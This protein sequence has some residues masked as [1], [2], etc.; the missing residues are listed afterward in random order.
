MSGFRSSDGI[1]VIAA[2][3]RLEALDPALTRPGRF[4]RKIEVAL[5][6]RAQREQILRL[7]A[8]NKPLEDD[9][10][11]DVLAMDTAMFSG[12]ALEHLL[13]EAA[14][15]AAR[16]D[17]GKISKRDIDAAFLS[18]TVG[19]E[20]TQ[21]LS[22]REARQTAVHE[23]GHALLTHL[24]EPETRLRRLSILPT[25]GA[26]NAAGYSMSIPRERTLHTRT[27]LE[28]RISIMLAGRAAEELVFGQDEVTTGAANDIS[29]ATELAMQMTRELGMYEKP[30]NMSAL[31]V[32]VA[33]DATE[34]MSR[35]Y[36]AALEI[37]NAN[38]NLLAKLANALFEEEALDE[39]RLTELLECVSKIP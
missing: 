39:K 23:A 3:N 38:V 31:G 17:A 29:R 9:V 16:R 21:R 26:L 32:N 5:P 20:H 36:K 10:A 14:V 24:L 18:V 11:L 12:A 34:L 19:G 22:E 30:V 8:R 15:Y 1:I 7:H 33:N 4:D 2:T 27:A 13:N 37:L 28:N 35:R 25:G 6:D